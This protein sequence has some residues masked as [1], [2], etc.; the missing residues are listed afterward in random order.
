MVLSLNL[1]IDIFIHEKGGCR[2]SF[3]V[4]CSA[5][6]VIICFIYLVLDLVDNESYARVIEFIAFSTIECMLKPIKIILTHNY[7]F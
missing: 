7:G 3:C 6:F 1:L 4:S 5:F 2:P